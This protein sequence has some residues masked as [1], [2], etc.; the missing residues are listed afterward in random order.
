MELLL[1]VIRFFDQQQQNLSDYRM[2]IFLVLLSEDSTSF[3]KLLDI[4]STSKSWEQR[5]VGLYLFT[6][7]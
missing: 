1:S 7:H 2:K 6:L 4:L 5:C 3:C